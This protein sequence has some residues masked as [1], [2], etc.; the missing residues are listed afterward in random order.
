MIDEFINSFIQEARELLFQLENELLLLEK[1][2]EDRLITDNIFRIMHNLKGAASMYGFNEMQNLAH[3]S[4]NLFDQIRTGSLKVSKGLIDDTLK[5]RDMLLAMLDQKTPAESN[6]EFLHHQE[7]RFFILF[8]PDAAVFERGLDPEKIIREIASMGR[9]VIRMHEGLTNWEK[10]KDHR[11]CDTKWEIYLAA[12]VKPASLKAVFL[13]YDEDEYKIDRLQDGI[14]I[15]D[16]VMD[17]FLRDHYPQYAGWEE[18]MKS[19][20]QE[21]LTTLPFTGNPS[22][23]YIIPETHT[24][25][26]SAFLPRSVADNTIKVSSQKL[27]ELMNLVSELVI[28]ASTLDAHAAGYKD[29]KISNIIENLEKLTKKFR[30]N[31]LDLRLIPVGNLLKKFN[32]QVRDLS[33]SLYK[34]VNFILEGQDTEI[35]KTILRSVESPLMHIIRNSIDHGIETPDERLRK[36]KAAEGKL[37]IT[38]FYS[39]ANVVIQVQ[40]DGAGIDLDKIRE[41]ALEKG[42][43]SPDQQISQQELLNLIMEPGFTTSSGVSLVS[44]RGVGMDVVRKEL[45]AIGGSIEIE[46]EKDLGT[47]FT[48]KLP[49][50]LSI[51]DTLM[52]EVDQSRILIPLLEVEYCYRESHRKIYSKNS[53]YLQYK[54]NLVPYISLRE[55]FSFPAFDRPDEMVI[56]ICK[57]GKKY[58]IVADDIVGEQQAVIKPLGELFINQPYYSGGSIMAD[59]NLALVLDTNYLFNQSVLN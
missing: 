1:A 6:P 33:Q 22:G 41:R 8:T 3:E 40:D 49:A 16:P 53:N 27:D 17:N 14:Y 25:E 18:H 56:V 26:Q 44:G 28:T 39:G 24:E 32:R 58:A 48:M 50:T 55:K 2:P 15:A 30:N 23:E 9:T 57:Y 31:A 46:T 19:A 52:L 36:G 20:Q 37:K 43:I 54:K 38:A 4:E 11:V 29:Q 12:G 7:D 34:K 45:N 47:S 21:L 5:A 35:D 59:G 51:I 42:Y 10:Q 13:F